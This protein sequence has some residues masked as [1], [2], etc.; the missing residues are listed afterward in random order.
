[1]STSKAAKAAKEQ[2]AKD[3]LRAQIRLIAIGATRGYLVS[4]PMD[5]DQDIDDR[6]LLL[7]VGLEELEQF[8]AAL[9]SVYGGQAITEYQWRIDKLAK[10]ATVN[11]ATEHLWSYGI[12]EASLC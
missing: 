4:D 11:S 5:E 9:R 1:M 10:F 7:V 12:K 3:A 2:A 6:D 8:I